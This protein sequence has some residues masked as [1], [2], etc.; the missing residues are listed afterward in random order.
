[1]ASTGYPTLT[2][3]RTHMKQTNN[4]A[5]TDDDLQGLLDSEA[6][7][8]ADECKVPVNPETD[9]PARLKQS[10]MRRVAR[11]YAL[12][13][14]PTGLITG[15]ADGTV[16]MARVSGIDREISRLERKYR[17]MGEPG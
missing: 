16:G 11:A 4:S 10:L 17:K 14:H 3:L 12:R 7:V 1:M 5:L 6:A 2:E 9:L 15:I 13:G 8:Q